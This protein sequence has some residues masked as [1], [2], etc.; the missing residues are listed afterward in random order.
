MKYLSVSADYD[1]KTGIGVFRDGVWNLLRSQQGSGAVR[2]G[3]ADDKP[4][5]AAF[6]P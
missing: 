2:F 4:I 1:G 5:A 6:L 3:A